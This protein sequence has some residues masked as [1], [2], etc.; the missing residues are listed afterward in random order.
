LLQVWLLKLQ[1]W[2]STLKQEIHYSFETGLRIER[3][4]FEASIQLSSSWQ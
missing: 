3:N 1:W 4:H 2:F